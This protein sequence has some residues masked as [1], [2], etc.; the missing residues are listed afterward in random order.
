MGTAPDTSVPGSE[1]ASGIEGQLTVSAQLSVR[2]GR[3]AV[4]FYRAAFGARELH[5]L[6]GEEDGEIAVA[7]LAVG[8]ASFWV[9]EES[10]AHKNYSPAALGGSTVRMLLIVADPQATI[11]QAVAAGATLVYPA[12]EDYGWLLGRIQD[13]AGHVWEI[14]RPVM[15]WPPG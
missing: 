11:D 13:P 9:A 10:P 7:Q 1:P 2:S 6:P 3:D 4:A 5:V 8:N 15:P 14:A 12:A